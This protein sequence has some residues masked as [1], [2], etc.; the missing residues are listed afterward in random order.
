VLIL[1]DRAAAEDAVQDAFLQLG[2]ALAR[3][4]GGPE[5][6]FGYL[7]TIVRNECYTALR[8]RRRRAEDAGEI[9]ECVSPDAS[10]EERMVLDAALKSLPA[11]QREVVYLKVFEGM[12]F[13]EIAGHCAIGI[14][15]A[16]SR[17]RYAMEALRRALAPD[18]SRT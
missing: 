17:Y 16:G 6:S 4:N 3:R 8:K 1:A 10:E 11:G 2:R 12:T 5:V 15:T 13:Q 9:I 18:R 14:N 7:A